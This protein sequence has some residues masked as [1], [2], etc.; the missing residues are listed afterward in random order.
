MKIHPLCHGVSFHITFLYFLS[1]S[2]KPQKVL[3]DCHNSDTKTA[4]CLCDII[5]NLLMLI[6]FHKQVGVLQYHLK[7]GAVQV[8]PYIIILWL[9]YS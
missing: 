5:R 8:K 6:L 2:E 9:N 4:A 7:P 1:Q 3:T